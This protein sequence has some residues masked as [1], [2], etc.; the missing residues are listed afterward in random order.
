MLFGLDKEDPLS[1]TKT[2][3]WAR[4]LGRSLRRIRLAEAD[5]E[6]F[7]IAFGLLRISVATQEDLDEYIERHGTNMFRS[8]RDLANPMCLANEERMLMKLAEM[9]QDYL[10]RYEF[11]G[12]VG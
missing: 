11:G 4:D 2:S 8:I 1:Q 5:N 6:N 9:C 12:S 10:S 3:M 7:R